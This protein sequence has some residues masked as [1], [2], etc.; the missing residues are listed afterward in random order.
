LLKQQHYTLAKVRKVRLCFTT[1]LNN[2]REHIQCIITLGAA[3]YDVIL[4]VIPTLESEPKKVVQKLRD[5]FK[6]SS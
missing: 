2:N 6:L 4:F 3:A 1:P 5:R